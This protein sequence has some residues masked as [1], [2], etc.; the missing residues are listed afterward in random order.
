MIGS[1]RVV[2][3]IATPR[4]RALLGTMNRGY[5]HFMDSLPPDLAQFAR[6][7]GTYVGA[8]RGEEIRGLEELN[9]LISCSPWLFWE[10]LESVDDLSFAT[11][12]LAGACLSLSSGVMDKL[13]DG[14]AHPLHTFLLLYEGLSQHAR[15]GFRDVLGS[16]PTFWKEFDRL[17]EEYWRCLAAEVAFRG[18]PSSLTLDAFVE[19]SGG[20]VSPIVVTIAAFAEMAGCGDLVPLIEQSFRMTFA[21]GQLHDDI[22]DWHSD[23]TSG[24]LTYFLTQLVPSGEWAETSDR[25]LAAE[26]HLE[27]EWTDVE[28]FGEALNLY[29]QAIVCVRGLPCPS[30][31]AYLKAYKARAEED[32]RLA[33]ARHLQRV[34]ARPPSS[35]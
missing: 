24:H 13:V 32:R 28:L 18:S 10:I 20:K 27:E 31:E 23:A 9:P 29:D 30:W 15:R 25:A 6:L 22:L 4:A 21:A 19:F 12:A 3:L 33:M 14:E 8:A 7:R 16:R 35:D 5:F 2:H 11:V 26:H 1:E 17:G 34:V